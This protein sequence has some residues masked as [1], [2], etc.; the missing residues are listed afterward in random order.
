MDEKYRSTP[1]GLQKVLIPLRGRDPFGR[2]TRGNASQPRATGSNASGVRITPL[3]RISGRTWVRLGQALTLSD[4]YE[5]EDTH[6]H[7]SPPGICEICEICGQPLSPCYR[8]NLR[9]A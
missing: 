8:R 7:H 1:E 5:I 3:F 9:F 2:M 4:P 6:S